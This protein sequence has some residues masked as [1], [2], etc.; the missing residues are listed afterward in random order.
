VSDNINLIDAHTDFGCAIGQNYTKHTQE[1][2]MDFLDGLQS[3]R[4]ASA[5]VRAGELHRVASVP[6][7]VVEIWLRQGLDIHKMTAREIVAKLHRDGLD[8]FVTSNK[9]I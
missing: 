6:T 5:A 2:P 4:L 7:A 1:I 9:R 3:E 8:A